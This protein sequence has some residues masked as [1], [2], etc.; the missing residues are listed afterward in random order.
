MDLFQSLPTELN[1][2]PKKNPKELVKVS[3]QE[4]GAECLFIG[5]EPAALSV[6]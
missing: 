1:K 3:N 6:A 4:W 5:S 2:A